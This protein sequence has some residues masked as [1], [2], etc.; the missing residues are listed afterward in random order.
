MELFNQWVDK[1]ARNKISL[2]DDTISIVMSYLVSFD[3]HGMMF[4][5][6]REG[7]YKE[8]HSNSVVS[9]AC[10][11]HNGLIEGE[12]SMFNI[13]G[14]L[15]RTCNYVGGK[16]HGMINIYTRHGIYQQFEFEDDVEVCFREFNRMGEIVSEEYQEGYGQRFS[17]W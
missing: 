14:N 7:E 9:L 6:V 15:S 16:K 10:T 2:S 3:E 8:Y 4:G 17:M 12:H 5:G 1:K 11:Y 13:N